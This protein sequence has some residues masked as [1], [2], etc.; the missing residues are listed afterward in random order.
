M[1]VIEMIT[2]AELSK[3]YHKWLKKEIIFSTLDNDIIR[4]DTPF[5]DRHN[6]SII[7]YVIP[8][9]DDK[10]KITDG[11]YALDD[12]EADGISI[13][14]SKNRRKIFLSQLA[15][16][17]VNYNENDNFLYIDSTIE[18]FSN[19]K[20]RILQAMLFTNDMFLTDN[21]RTKTLFLE[22]VEKYFNT[23]D[24][25]ALENA[26]FVGSTGLTHKYEFSIPGSQRRDIPDKL[27]KVLS[28]PR[29]EMY[30]K[31]L[32]TDVKYTRNV[33]KPNTIFY[34]F[35]NN[36]EKDIA[37]PI[38]SLMSDEKIKVIPFTDRKSF[39]TELRA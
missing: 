26:S 36:Q 22:D 23:N 16:Y 21:K 7:L 2:A 19:D 31:V 1:E 6:D 8:G 37:S 38:L 29:N 34:T 39:V 17:G 30:A 3:E 33:V 9:S 11:G 35:I 14:R 28:S 27:I 18:S 15:S 20:H 32:A 13:T 5:Y 10:L 12:L 24:I 4:I 25:R